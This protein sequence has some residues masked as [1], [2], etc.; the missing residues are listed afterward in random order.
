MIENKFGSVK[1]IRTFVSNK[2]K[3]QMV[4]AGIVLGLYFSFIAFRVVTVKT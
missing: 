1:S 2:N 4:Y 3:Q